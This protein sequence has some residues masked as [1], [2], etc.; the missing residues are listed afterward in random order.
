[1][2][3]IECTSFASMWR[4]YGYYKENKVK[5]LQQISDTQYTAEV[6]G[7]TDE[8]Y[9]VSIDIKHPKRSKCNCPHA[10]GK[11]IV[12]KHKMAVYFAAFPEEAQRIYDEAMGYQEK[13]EKRREDIYEK[14]CQHIKKMK[15]NE[16][17]EALYN[18]L[19]FGPDWQYDNFVQELGLN[20]EC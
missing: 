12:C 5:N 1:M 10:D 18:L 17:Q 11:L 7:S 2:G 6:E 15:K 13:E 3:M 19:M 4:G 9:K 16:L 20:D 8:P 14:V